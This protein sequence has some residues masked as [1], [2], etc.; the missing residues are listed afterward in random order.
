MKI[1]KSYGDIFIF[2]FYP[3]KSPKPKTTEF[4]LQ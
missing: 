2:L 4:N 1:P 3:S